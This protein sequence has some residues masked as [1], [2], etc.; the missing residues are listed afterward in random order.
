METITRKRE[1]LRAIRKRGYLNEWATPGD[2]WWVAHCVPGGL[3]DDA[4]LIDPDLA[5]RLLTS[6]LLEQIGG[7]QWAMDRQSRIAW[8]RIRPGH[9][10]HT[11]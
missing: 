11:E 4:A 7:R 6:G 10:G 1:A 3:S 9:K 8:Y 2:T 5:E